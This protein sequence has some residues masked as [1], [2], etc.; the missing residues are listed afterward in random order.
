MSVYIIYIYV[1]IHTL[2][3]LYIEDINTCTFI[4]SYSLKTCTRTTLLKGPR[5]GHAKCTLVG[6][7]Q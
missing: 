7:T 6:G 3:T 4:E 1:H 2:Y 5:A